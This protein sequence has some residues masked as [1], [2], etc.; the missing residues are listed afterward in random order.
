MSNREISLRP[1]LEASL[2][3]VLGRTADNSTEL[4]LEHYQRS[5]ELWKQLNKPLGVANTN[6][7]LGLWW[8][9]YTVRHHAE[10]KM[11]RE[12][13]CSYFQQLIESFEIINRPDL[14][15]KLINAWAE[16]LE[17][18]GRWDELENIA[19][20]AIELYKTYIQGLTANYQFKIDGKLIEKLVEDLA[21]ELGEIRPIELQVVGAQLQRDN[22]TNLEKYL[23]L[24][25]NPQAELVEKYLASVVK[26]CG[27][28][29][30]KS[31][32]LLLLLFTDE[33]NT[34]PLKTKAE[35]LKE[36]KFSA[37][38]LDL[39][40]NIFVDSGLVFLLP[41]NP[42]NQYQL[43]HDYL[44]GFIR[45][46]KEVEMLEA[47]KREREQR[48]WNR[49]GK[50]LQTLKGHKSYVNTVEFSPNGEM[51]ATASD[52]T[53]VKLW[54]RLGKELQN[55]KGHANEINSVAFSPDGEM[56]ATA[57]DDTIVK[58]WNRLGKELQTL[59]GHANEINSVAFSPDGEMIA[60]ASDDYTVKL[61]IDWRIE[62]LTQRG[63]EWLNDYLISHPQELEELKICQ[64]EA[65]LKAAARSW[66]I[67]GDKLARKSKEAEKI[68]AAVAVFE[69]AKKWNPELNL[70][71]NFRTWAESLAEA[72]KLM[73][74][75]TKL[76]RVGKIEVAVEKYEK[77][78]EL[79]K[80]AFIPTL[81]NIDP[82]AKAKSE[83]VDSS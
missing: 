72:E 1:E 20:R 43:V 14:V 78:K 55:L 25:D 39:V 21:E 31:A 23:E 79:D 44:V 49:Q 3:F 50:L 4:A 47:L 29:N 83:V 19:K 5:L 67:E 12:K 53:I 28:E 46:R 80:A 59:K 66:V 10:K 30:Q 82:E 32:W 57:S 51:I 76:A 7:H 11:A 38:E 75:G 77:A 9:S 13:A 65:R 69:K 48:Q 81:Q 22:I 34:R 63:C 60:T 18:L 6:Y 16:V 56:I 26:D 35:L 2:E 61:W 74:E 17:N 36:S 41:Q 54:N 52:D 68:E 40:L 27:A 42:V 58:L 45:Q 62:D 33:N 24:G 37:E 73:E 15:V 64:T 71:A 70:K 8:R